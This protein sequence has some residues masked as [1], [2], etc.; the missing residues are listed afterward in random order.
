MSIAEAIFEAMRQSGMHDWVGGGGADP[1]AASAENFACVLDNLSLRPSDRV[2]DFGCGIGR[3]SVPLADFLST[4]ELVGV[5][6]VPAQIRFCQAE[7]A[8]RFRNASFYC[9]DARN[10]HYDRFI[11]E[12]NM[13]ISEDDFLANRAAS[14]D[15]VVAYSVFTHFDPPMAAKYLSFLK[16][17]TKEGG[18]LFLS[19]FFD[20]DANPTHNRL[21]NGEHCYKTEDLSFVLFSLQL[22]GELVAD[23]GLQ[24]RRITYGYWREGRPNVMLKGEHPQDIA[25]LYRPVEFPVDFDPVRY[26]ELNRDVAE[27]GVD[28]VRHYLDHG[29]RE[30]RRFR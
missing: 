26:L 29:Q 14:F 12:D 5:D 2:L 24:I 6:I 20:H 28:P 9:T 4:G 30:G 22:F 1:A 8:S 23:A 15:L 27:A 17:L 16:Q 19:W 18:W 25:I 21:S 10:P 7:I 3:T 11:S 13:V